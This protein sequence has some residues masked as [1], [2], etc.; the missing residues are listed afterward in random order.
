MTARTPRQQAVIDKFN[1]ALETAISDRDIERMSAEEMDDVIATGLSA[2]SPHDVAA[3]WLPGIEEFVDFPPDP[4]AASA[5]AAGDAKVLILPV[6][7]VERFGV[8]LRDQPSAAG[9]TDIAHL[10]SP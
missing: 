9:R 3:F 6:V 1:T 7:R 10:R 5:R 4:D 8:D 2:L